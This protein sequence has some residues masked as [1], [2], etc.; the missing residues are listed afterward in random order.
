MESLQEVGE[1]VPLR[2]DREGKVIREVA[3]ARLRLPLPEHH[4][5][6]LD[7][8]VALI[9]NLC[10]HV[11]RSERP[12]DEDES[13]RWDEKPDGTPEHWLDEGWK[14]TPLPAAPTV[15]KL[16][17][18]VTTATQADAVELAQTYTR[19]WPAQENAIR[20]WL[21]P[22]GIDVNHGYGKT[23]VSNSEVAKKRE[24]LQRR[25][26]NVQRW[27]DGARQRMHTASKRDRRRSQLTKERAREL[28]RVLK[29]H[30]RE[31]ERQ[32]LDRG[33]LRQTIKEEKAAADAEIE[34]YQPREWKAYHTSNREVARV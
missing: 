11:R 28:A 27:A 33:L 10:R 34:E 32:D 13:R 7:L 9:R 1:F 18:I 19:R 16:I 24:A 22:R 26:D 15:P 6:E 14:A 5:Q 8:R 30:Q 20:D 17:P 12:E 29:D 2:V 31:L 23:P 4:G 3:L 25:L 21:I